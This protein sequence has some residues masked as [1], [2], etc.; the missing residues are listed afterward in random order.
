MTSSTQRNVYGARLRRSWRGFRARD[1]RR[2]PADPGEVDRVLLEV[3]CGVAIRVDGVAEQILDTAGSGHGAVNDC[4]AQ[5]II[6]DL[7]FGGVGN[8]G[9]GKYHSERGFRAYTNTR[10]ALY[11]S[12]RLDLG[13]RY[14]PHDYNQ[15]LR[16][17][18]H[19]RS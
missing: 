17:F 15:T 16:T 13:V 3:S 6:Q 7:P 4:T 19:L 5:P 1:R 18:A 11:D 8:S 14:P 10:G 2:W 12:T 9:R